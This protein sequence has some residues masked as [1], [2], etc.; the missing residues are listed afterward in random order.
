MTLTL[1][2]TQAPG[3]SHLRSLGLGDV[4][5][6][7]G[8]KK[9]AKMSSMDIHKNFQLYLHTGDDIRRALKGSKGF[10][11]NWMTWPFG[12]PGIQVRCNNYYIFY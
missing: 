1:Q 12:Q 2:G 4:A 8:Y 10:L 5:L 11:I 3:R 9:G 7:V 6:S